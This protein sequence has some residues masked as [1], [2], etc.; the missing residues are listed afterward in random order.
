MDEKPADSARVQRFVGLR[1][2]T[3]F[4]SA[5]EEELEN[6]SSGHHFYHPK[7]LRQRV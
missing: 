2:I 1:R 3:Y 7:K 5:I 6:Q 4:D